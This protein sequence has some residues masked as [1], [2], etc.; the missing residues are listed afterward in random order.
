MLYARHHG[1]DRVVNTFAMNLHAATG[2]ERFDQVRSFVGEDASGSFGILSGHERFMTSLLFGLARFADP[3]G[4]W[5]FLA[6]PGGLLYFTGNELTISTRQY[7]LDA[8]YDRISAALGEQL[9][10]DEEKLHEVKESLRRM[11]EEMLRRMWEMRRGGSG[12]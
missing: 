1:A 6:M 8:D 12:S 2:S 11:E 5:R 3:Q 7:L 9:L 10:A 4:E